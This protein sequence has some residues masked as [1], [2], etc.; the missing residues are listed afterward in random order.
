MDAG[1]W[2]M[3]GANK[4]STRSTAKK[5]TIR[6][7]RHLARSGGTLISKCLGSMDGVVLISEIHPAVL[8]VT[9]PMW[10]AVEWFDLVSKKQM[11]RWKMVRGPRFEQ[12]VWVCAQA[13]ESRGE[14]LVLR[15]WSHID[16]YGHPFLKNPKMG[17]GLRDALEGSFE[18]VE[19]CSV[20]HPIDQYMSFSKFPEI[21]QVDMDL[22]FDG[23][24][25]MAE[26]A[27]GCQGGKGFVR[28]EDLTRDPDT[29]LRE[30]CGMLDIA[31]DPKYSERWASYTTVTGDVRKGHGR[32]AGDT[33]IRT[34]ERKPMDEGLLERF[35]ADERYQ[36]ACAL[37]GYEP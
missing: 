31:F 1:D 18:I 12:F 28:Y 37:L 29:K 4:K 11:S 35:R 27:V 30:L 36:R 24:L 19:A 2:V 32:G 25:A 9:N 8:N 13:A 3:A 26:Y 6:I 23:N 10:Q 17:S 20:R 7:L 34:L 22:F 16:Y 15:D 33:E 5:P 21:P 14:T